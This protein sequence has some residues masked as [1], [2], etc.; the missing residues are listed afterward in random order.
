MKTINKTITLKTIF[1][2]VI[3][4]T[5]LAT[6][7]QD[8][9]G[10]ETYGSLSGQLGIHKSTALAGAVALNMG[11]KTKKIFGAGLGI[12]AIKFSS[13]K[14]VYLPVYADF[15]YFFPPG[16]L[17]QAFFIAQPGYGLYNSKQT[18]TTVVGTYTIDNSSI[19]SKGGFYF[20][21]GLGL[22]GKEGFSPIV[23]IRYTSY[24]FNHEKTGNYYSESPNARTSAITINFGI[25]F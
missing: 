17:F 9:K 12:E 5:F 19:T 13:H 21:S 23:T 16:A 18:H 1:T 10:P 3:S 4:L 22:S 8:K 20:G 11:I 2:F 14:S 7:S 6:Y 15:R 24:A 25:A